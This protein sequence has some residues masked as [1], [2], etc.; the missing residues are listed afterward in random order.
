MIIERFAEID[1]GEGCAHV[2]DVARFRREHRG[3]TSELRER[4]QGATPSEGEAFAL[5]LWESYCSRVGGYRDTS[6]TDIAV[7]FPE[8]WR[9]L[10]PPIDCV[11]AVGLF[12]K[13]ALTGGRAPDP[14]RSMP[15]ARDAGAGEA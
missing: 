7:A 3:K 15:P 4:M 11:I 6:G 8:D 10:I 13:H 14:R 9:E 12:V 5:E 2:F 1:L